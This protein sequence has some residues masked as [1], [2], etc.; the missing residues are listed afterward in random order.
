MGWRDMKSKDSPLFDIERKI[1]ELIDVNAKAY[2]Y[3]TRPLKF[4]E[5]IMTEDN[6]KRHERMTRR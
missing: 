6:L 2:S 4:K 5:A 1:K 3:Q